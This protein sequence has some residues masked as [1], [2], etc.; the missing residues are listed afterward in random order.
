MRAGRASRYLTVVNIVDDT[1]RFIST[2]SS[3][4]RGFEYFSTNTLGAHK[5]G[6]G[7]IIRFSGVQNVMVSTGER[8]KEK[9][10]KNVV[11]SLEKYN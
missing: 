6:T 11:P 3:E 5:G 4:L 8:L 1:T 10:K 9:E 7:I 2:A